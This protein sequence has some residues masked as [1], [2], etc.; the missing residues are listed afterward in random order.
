[1]MAFVSLLIYQI[2]KRSSLRIRPIIDEQ[3]LTPIYFFIEVNYDRFVAKIIEV[4][5]LKSI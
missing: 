2:I 4:L 3:L 5:A 1:M